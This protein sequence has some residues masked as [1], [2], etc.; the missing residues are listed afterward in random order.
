[1]TTTV[2]PRTIVANAYGHLIRSTNWH[3]LPNGWRT[4]GAVIDITATTIT[5][6]F[7]AS[8]SVV[9]VDV[10]DNGWQAVAGVVD[11][12]VAAR[13]LPVELSSGWQAGITARA[14]E[15]AR[16]RQ[17]VHVLEQTLVAGD[18]IVASL[19]AVA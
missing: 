3:R 18:A 16:L 14:E 6:A 15:I 13:Y 10:A 11:L 5:V 7:P 8:G 12:L 4:A 19:R 9:N 17:R 2:D 1:M